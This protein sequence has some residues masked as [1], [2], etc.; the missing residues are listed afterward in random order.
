MG[1]V[2]DERITA[3]LG[4][5]FDDDLR[6]RLGEVLKTLGAMFSDRGWGLGGSQ[7]IETVSVEIAGKRIVV[8]SETYVGLSVSGERSLVEKIV[9][10]VND[11]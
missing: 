11:K 4:D 2:S 6:K 9:A 8:E 3:V 10:L 7:E 5:E 1:D